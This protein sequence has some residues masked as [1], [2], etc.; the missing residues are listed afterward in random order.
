M[1]TLAVTETKF[2]MLEALAVAVASDPDS[3][4]EISL[5]S[6]CE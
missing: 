2:P 5:P 3:G 6:I 1:L 4:E